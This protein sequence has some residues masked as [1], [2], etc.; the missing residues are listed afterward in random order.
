[1]DKQ[2]KPKA[3]LIKDLEK[4][5]K[6]VASDEASDSL[7]HQLETSEHRYRRLFEAAQ[8][9]ILILDAKTAQISDVNP[10]LIDMLGYNKEEFLGKKL[11]EVG[12]FHNIEATKSVFIKL[13]TQQYIRYEDMPLQTK[14]GKLINVEFVSNVYPVDGTEVIQ[15]NI[16]DITN[17]KQ[18]EEALKQNQQQQLEMRDQFLSRMSHEL[19]SPLTPIHQFITILLDGIAGDLNAEQ[20]EYLLIV[21][22]NVNILRNMISDLLA[23]TRAESG[24]LGVELRCVYLNDLTSQTYKSF[25]LANTKNLSISFDVPGDLPPVC[26]DSNR[27][28]QILDNLLDNAIKFTPE[29]GKVNVRARVSKQSPGFIR[30]AVSDTGCGIAPSERKHIFDY[31]YQ[32]ENNI[33]SS[34]KGLGIG[35]YICKELVSS[36]GGQIWFKS[37]P[38]HGSTFFFTLPVFS[39]ENQLASIVKAADLIT[40]SIA[41][42]TVEVSHVE[43]C[44]LQNK[45]VQTALG[46]VWDALQSCTLPNL[47][48]LL[49]RVPHTV[50]KE[51]FFIV[52]CVNQ[53]SAEVLVKQL[54]SQLA[55]RQSI[56]DSGLKPKVSFILLDIRSK[57]NGTLSKK[58][59]KKNVVEHI[60]ELMKTTLYKE[61]GL[62]EWEK[63]SNSR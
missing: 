40:H 19:R 12:P 43:K 49:P 18:A 7:M 33:E 26:A 52:A 9:G 42:I 10:F 47:V 2:I 14:D 50:S 25:Q 58:L 41:L 59:V 35:L 13:Q 53:S 38:G 22:R 62:Y 61:G 21:L 5:Q 36:L 3:Q 44:P 30:I 16:R 20:R 27:I 39:L 45:P 54:R 57:R 1:M 60:E 17:R 29:K 51:F 46:N 55:R 31:L 48:V 24:K 4:L 32:I 11:W 23:V 56:R 34:H 8:D 28:G 37:Q 15:C 63:S 6:K